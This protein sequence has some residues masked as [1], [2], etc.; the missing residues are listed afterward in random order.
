MGKLVKT[1]ACFYLRKPRR[2]RIR[3]V[4]PSIGEILGLTTI[5]VGEDEERSPLRHQRFDHLGEIAIHAS[6]HL[7]FR[8]IGVVCR[9]PSLWLP[10]L[11]MQTLSKKLF[12]IQTYR[13]V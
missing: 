1:L 4:K 7:W 12:S 2:I 13:F 3:N 11:L 10:L 9:V 8:W 5:Q 6:S